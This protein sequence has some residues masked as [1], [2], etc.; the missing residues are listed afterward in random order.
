MEDIPPEELNSLLSHFFIKVRKLNGEEFEPRT[1][2][3]FQRSFDRYL[4]QHGKDYNIIQDKIF[5][6]SRKALESK[7]KQLRL[8]GKGDRPNKALG[9]T[10]DELE[11]FWNKKQ[12]GDHSPEALLRTVWL[13]S[14]MHFGWRAPYEHCKVLLGD[15]EIRQE[16]GGE[17]TEYIIWKTERGS[18]T[19]TGGK[20]F[21]AERYFS[22]RI[23][24]TGGDRC[25]VNIFKTFLARRRPDMMKPDSPPYLAVV[26]SPRTEVWYKRQPLGVHSLGQFLKTMADAVLCADQIETSTP[27]PRANPGHLTTSC[28]R[29]VGNLT[30]TWVG[31]GKLNQKCRPSSDFLFRAPKSL[32]AINTCLDEMEE[33]KGRDR[34]FVSDW[35]TKKGLQK[36]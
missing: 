34:T 25:P 31:W 1:L 18:K 32:I 22:P 8:S 29:G 2:T 16:E 19:R 15:L 12:L 11:K 23:Y 33:F 27:L 9:L 10:N 3:S 17:R 30:F 26:K 28:A 36:L 14:A 6:S 13:S 7:R 21:G 35:L 24:S 20:E 5:E 4:R